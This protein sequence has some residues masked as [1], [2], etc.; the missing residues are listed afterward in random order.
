M[1]PTRKRIRAMADV[2][3]EMGLWKDIP[4]NLAEY[5]DQRFILRASNR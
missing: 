4:G 5:A 1:I 3:V 2:M